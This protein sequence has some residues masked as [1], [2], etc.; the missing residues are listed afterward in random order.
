AAAP[1]S[2]TLQHPNRPALENVFG[3]MRHLSDSL[4]FA[5]MLAVM[6]TAPRA[7]A[8]AFTF[9]PPPT[10]EPYLV[11]YLAGLGRANGF[12]VVDWLQ[13]FKPYA[14]TELLYFRDDD[15]LNERGSEVVAQTLAERL[16][17]R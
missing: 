14:R 8:S 11:N 7:H 12:D 15:H 16:Q 17:S 2:N 6:P 13:A 4:N 1:E 5:V 10:P 3:R 9:T